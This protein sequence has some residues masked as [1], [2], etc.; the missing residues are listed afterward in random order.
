MGA[1]QWFGVSLAWAAMAWGCA[2]EEG[3]ASR[4]FRSEALGRA[5]TAGAAATPHALS[6]PNSVAEGDLAFAFP[7]RRH[8]MPK[9]SDA[10]APGRPLLSKAS[11]HALAE[12]YRGTAGEGTFEGE[13]TYDQ[14]RL[15]S[16]RVAPCAALGPTPQSD[17]DRLCW[18]ELRLV[19]Q[20]ILEDV[21][22]HE[23]FAEAFAEDRAIHLLF[24][25]PGTVTLSPEEAHRA[26]GYRTRIRQAQPDA[27][28]VVAPL[29][30]A[31]LADF[32]ALRDRVS[33]TFV[34]AAVALRGT[35]TATRDLN[36]VGVRPEVMGYASQA[37]SW[38]AK[39]LGFVGAFSKADSVTK[40]TGFTL[41]PGREPAQLDQWLFVAMVP[42]G[43]DWRAEPMRVLAADTG[44]DIYVSTPVA[45]SSMSTEASDLE[46]AWHGGP[47]APALQRQVALTPADARRMTP[48]LRDR[49]QLLVAN[50]TCASCHKMGQEAFDFHAFSYFEDRN[51]SVSPR[52]IT[53]VALDLAW[54]A[55]H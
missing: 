11:Y 44:L 14:V 38:R 30:S 33:R 43:A 42:R 48:R 41:P 16:L 12:A 10:I 3:D 17:T 13:N 31:E 22:M 32:E 24:D 55:Q 35:G 50:T 46:T 1:R 36:A 34:N 4:G 5:S 8:A 47:H 7:L 37:A 21:R 54:I 52:V 27:Q 51:L 18:P 40:M 20:P 53:D 45:D 39:V 29:S 49:R 19:L 9:A 15:V 2:A 28:G 25:V 6:G 23:R 26:T